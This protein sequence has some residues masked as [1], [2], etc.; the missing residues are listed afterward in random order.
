MYE[1][2]IILTK[3]ANLTLESEVKNDEHVLKAFAKAKP[4]VGDAHNGRLITSHVS[5]FHA[6]KSI[7]AKQLKAALQLCCSNLKNP[8]S[9]LF[10]KI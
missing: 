6:G 5:N 3:F 7:E 4:F 8:T 9:S 10:D 2:V 1:L